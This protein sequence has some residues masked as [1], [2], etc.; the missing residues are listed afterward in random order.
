MT[1]TTPVQTP[2][3]IYTVKITLLWDYHIRFDYRIH[4]I[5]MIIAR[6]YG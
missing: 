6:G 3:R 4:F 1:K 5:L 2:K